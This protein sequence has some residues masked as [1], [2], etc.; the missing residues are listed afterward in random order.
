MV[1]MVRHG[2]SPLQP[3]TLDPAQPLA[4]SPPAQTNTS[5]PP[6]TTLP[7]SPAAQTSTIAPSNAPTASGHH[8]SAG[9]GSGSSSRDSSS[10][11]GTTAGQGRAAAGAA[12]MGV[13]PPQPAGSGARHSGAAPPSASANMAQAP[14][15]HGQG[16]QQQPGNPGGAQPT[17]SSGRAAV[18]DGSCGAG[19]HGEDGVG[20]TAV[21]G[22]RWWP[23]EVAARTYCVGVACP[24][25]VSEHAARAC[26]AYVVCLVGALPAERVRVCVRLCMCLQAHP[27]AWK[28][29]CT[30]SVS[31]HVCRHTTW[32]LCPA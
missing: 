31:A 1:L 30:P 27:T 12:D 3:P 4:S 20:S 7:S 15:L 25:V 22:Q 19:G 17:H 14:Y 28:R 2:D 23:A 32:T 24:P 11:S 10:G 6:R 29:A 9:E 21:G 5:L 16:R 18:G 8:T 13:V 26:E